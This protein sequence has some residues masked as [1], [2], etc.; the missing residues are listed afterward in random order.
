MR[1]GADGWGH[2]GAAAVEFAVV[3]PGLLLIIGLVIAG[4]R[5]AHAQQTVHQLAD[6]GARAASLARTAATARAD[7]AFVIHSDG[8]DA[9]LYCNG[10]PGSR[11]DVSGFATPVGE[12]ATVTVVVECTVTLSDLLLPG[13]PGAWTVSASA[14]SPLDRFRSRR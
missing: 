11:V 1:G 14:S 13:L 6:S 4:G 9:G 12:A 5:L 10:G 2:R 8:A 7:A 3:I